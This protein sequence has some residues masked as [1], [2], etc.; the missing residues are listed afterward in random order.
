MLLGR[1]V[2][3]LDSR[4]LRALRDRKALRERVLPVLVVPL[5]S[6]DLLV[7]R[8]RQE[9]LVSQVRELPEPRV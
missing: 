9:H 5:V 8:D 6:K 4:A 3:P 7:S 1:L 2:G